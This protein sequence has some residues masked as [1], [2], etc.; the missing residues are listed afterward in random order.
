VGGKFFIRGMLRYNGEIVMY[1]YT[2]Y[3]DQ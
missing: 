3:V 2:K 1:R